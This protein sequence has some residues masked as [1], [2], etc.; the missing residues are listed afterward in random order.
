MERKEYQAIFVLAADIEKTDSGEFKF[1]EKDNKNRALHGELRFKA[2]ERLFQDGRVQ[3]LVMIGGPQKGGTANGVQK[4]EIMKRYLI[5]KYNI[6]PAVIDTKISES[7]TAGNAIAIYEYFSTHPD[8]HP[9]GCA[10]LTNFYHIPRAIRIFNEYGLM[11]RSIAAES[12]L[13]EGQEEQK[14][15]LEKYR[16]EAMINR[17]ESE[18]NGLKDWEQG[19]Y[20]EKS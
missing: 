7:S 20:G 6:P 9:R 15:I 10:F 11:L 19:T 16:Q 8:F 5:E 14:D 18:I 13:F 12:I 3:R 4:V 17:I 2:A 1:I